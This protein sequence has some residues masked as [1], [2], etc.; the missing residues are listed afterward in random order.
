[1]AK[2]VANLGIVGL[3]V[4]RDVGNQ[5]LLL[6]FDDLRDPRRQPCLRQRRIVDP[7]DGETAQIG[8][9]NLADGGFRNLW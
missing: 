8:L 5:S 1:M 9:E 2:D 6:F 3:S 7:L 4:S